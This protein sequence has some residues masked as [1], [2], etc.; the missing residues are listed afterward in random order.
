MKKVVV[1]LVKSLNDTLTL[2]NVV[3][4]PWFGLGVF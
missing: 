4:M 2:N 3:E 1:K